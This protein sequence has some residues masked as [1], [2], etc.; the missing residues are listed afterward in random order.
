MAEDPEVRDLLRRRGVAYIHVQELAG[1]FRRELCVAPAGDDWVMFIRTLPSVKTAPLGDISRPA[2]N[3]QL[4]G[5]PVAFNPRDFPMIDGLSCLDLPPGTLG[6]VENLLQAERPVDRGSPAAQVPRPSFGL[7]RYD[8]RDL[9]GI[10]RILYPTSR[11]WGRAPGAFPGH[12]PLLQ[13]P[14]SLRISCR[15]AGADPWEEYARP[16]YL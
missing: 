4:D 13:V 10:C 8:A 5:G 1:L 3:G 11:C 14:R 16:L 2:L 6:G 9:H 7:R 12:H 15:R